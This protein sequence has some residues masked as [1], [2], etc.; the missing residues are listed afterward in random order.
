MSGLV[1]FASPMC[2]WCWGFSPNIEKLSQAYPAKNIRLVLTPFRVDTTEPMD[3]KLRDYV[4]GQWHKVHTTTSQLFDFNFSVAD[5]FIYNTKLVGQA[6]KAF[7][8]Q[9]AD[10]ELEFVKILQQA[11]YVYNK[12]ITD[13]E[14]L[15]ELAQNFPIDIQE[16]KRALHSKDI[17]DE[18]NQDFKLCQELSVHS[19]PT[20]MYVLQ[21]EYKV[22]VEGYLPYAELKQKIETA[23]D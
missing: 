5:D 16:F 15:L 18:L 20:L 22:L 9:I 21:D 11:F 3:K 17:E 6:I 8:Q 7:K 4:L 12:N 1:Y 2:S 10:K 19:Y 13:E 23:I 14:V